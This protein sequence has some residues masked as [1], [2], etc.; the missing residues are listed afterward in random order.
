MLHEKYG[1][2]VV[3]NHLF[4]LERIVKKAKDP[5][6]N[7]QQKFVVYKINCKKCDKTDVE[8]TKRLLETRV[9]E[10]QKSQNQNQKYFDVITK[11]IKDMNCK[12]NM[13]YELEK[14]KRST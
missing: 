11:N 8:Q 10:H 4:M 5:T 12:H 14:C 9:C 3:Y 2:G 7:M 6:E 1:F 13:N